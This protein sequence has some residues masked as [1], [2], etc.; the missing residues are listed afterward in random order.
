MH[1]IGTGCGPELIAG[2]G[3]RDLVGLGL[4]RGPCGRR[5]GGP[6]RRLPW[7]AAVRECEGAH[8]RLPARGAGEGVVLLRVPEG[9]VV[10]W[11]DRHHAVVAPAVEARGLRAGAGNERRFALG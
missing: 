4:A 8:A 1:R 9:A 2:V 5:F 11:V 10:S 7:L 6:V 3:E